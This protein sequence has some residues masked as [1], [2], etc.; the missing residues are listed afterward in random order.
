MTTS[1][2]ET[3][4]AEGA[5]KTLVPVTPTD[6]FNAAQLAFGL[7]ADLTP[8]SL[9]LNNP[10]ISY[11][12]WENIGRCIG[13]VGNAWQWWVG[14]WLNFGEMKFGEESAQ[15]V[16]TQ[17]SRYDIAKRI[18]PVDQGR[19]QN[20]RS[21][22][23]R[24]AA[25]RRRVEL[26]FSHHEEVAALDPE[27][28]VVWLQRAVTN[29]LTRAE[30]RQAIR[31]EKNPPEP[32]PDPVPPANGGDDGD[33]PTRTEQL[34]KAA[35]LVYQQAQSTSDGAY[36]VPQSAMAQLAAALGED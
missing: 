5:S 30:L 16:D 24:V 7:G 36:L 4:V 22:C 17:E 32:D 26:T 23:G 28:Q 10:S 9:T 33:G 20:I 25:S 3:Q 12:D 29:Q 2:D 34:L 31:D 19:L 1:I 13:F 27:E 14:D 21:V 15:A 11:I 8:V 35:Q 18:T 6:G